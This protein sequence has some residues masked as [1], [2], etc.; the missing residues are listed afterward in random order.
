MSVEVDY[1]SPS[2]E[3]YREDIRCARKGHR[4]DAC[5]ETIRPGDLYCDTFIVF[6]RD[7]ERIRRCLRCGSIFRILFQKMLRETNGE[8]QPALRLDCGHTWR[9]RWEEDPPPEIARLAFLTPDE[10][11]AEAKELALPGF[12]RGPRG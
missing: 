7:P 3:V 4:C 9:A 1:D 5:R 10:I 8:E 12:E 11:Q 2:A 6:E